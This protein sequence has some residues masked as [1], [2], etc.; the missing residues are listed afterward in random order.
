MRAVVAVSGRPLVL[1]APSV[2]SL[3]ERAVSHLMFSLDGLNVAD[4]V[5]MSFALA[6]ARPLATEEDGEMTAHEHFVSDAA[7]TLLW[8]QLV[9]LSLAGLSTQSDT[10]GT[11]HANLLFA[12]ACL[13]RAAP[14]A[15]LPHDVGTSLLSLISALV[16]DVG[17]WQSAHSQV[18]TQLLARLVAALGL[19]QERSAVSE[20]WPPAVRPADRVTRLLR[21]DAFDTA[22]LS[23][24]LLLRLGVRSL[25]LTDSRLA[26][27]VDGRIAAIAAVD[28]AGGQLATG[29]LCDGL[30]LLHA[31]GQFDFDDEWVPRLVCVAANAVDRLS[32]SE[33]A[34]LRALTRRLAAGL[35][36]SP[37]ARRYEPGSPSGMASALA[38]QDWFGR[39]KREETSW[40]GARRRR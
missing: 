34:A 11:M 10:F 3:L 17:F 13:C 2:R 9:P 22:D 35:P 15:S 6:L 28:G 33:R 27:D 31:C 7:F 26:A 39:R 23:S 21:F 16:R 1:T 12:I 19:L 25:G 8:E 20:M 24:L 18:D 38:L 14:K 29:E 5:S 30:L 4:F 40:M 36:L 37:G 32:R